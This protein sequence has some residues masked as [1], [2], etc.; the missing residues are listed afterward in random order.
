[1]TF[2]IA[3]LL[4]HSDGAR[5]FFSRQGVLFMVAAALFAV[6]GSRMCAVRARV[7]S[8]TPLHSLHRQFDD[9]DYEPSR[10]IFFTPPLSLGL[11]RVPDIFVLTAVA[12][13]SLTVALMMPVYGD[14]L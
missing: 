4:S 11:D 9:A 1:M 13:V 14:S 5:T 8:R 7:G 6:F 10:A 2:S 12:I 3:K